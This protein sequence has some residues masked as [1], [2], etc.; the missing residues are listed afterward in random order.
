MRILTAIAAAAGLAVLASGAQAETRR[1]LVVVEL[2]TSQGCS[3]CPPADAMM[4]R[5]AGR[6]DVLPLALHVDY[7]DYI[8][9]KDKFA[10]P[11]HTKRQKGYARAAGSN[12]VYTPQMIVMGQDEVAGAHPM[13]VA[14][15]VGKH[16]ERSPLI[17]LEAARRDGEL[18]VALEP[19]AELPAGPLLLQ[20]V[21]YA[22][23]KTVSITR[24]ELAGH[25][26]D[27]ANVVEDWQVV[28]R[29]DGQGPLQLS[30]PLEGGLE[31]AVIVQQGPFGPV[32]AA[33]RAE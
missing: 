22:P 14:D 18:H 3:A 17:A 29:W 20:L 13:E 32:L 12:M 25:T 4:H 19:L 33:A 27:Y 1:S 11:A 15:M 7:W 6:D 24:G 5:L 21:R 26:L 8:G 16:L 31:A 2:F 30:V 10:D 23:L 28:E 9:W